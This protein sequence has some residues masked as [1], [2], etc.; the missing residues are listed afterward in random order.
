MLMPRLW[1]YQSVNKLSCFHFQPQCPLIPKWQP[2]LS[3][4][5]SWTMTWTVQRR[6]CWAAFEPHWA[7]TTQPEIWPRGWRSKRWELKTD[8]IST[9]L[10]LLAHFCSISFSQLFRFRRYV[11]FCIVHH[12]I[13]VTCYDKCVCHLRFCY[14]IAANCLFFQWFCR[15]VITDMALMIFLFIVC[16]YRLHRIL[17]HLVF[18]IQNVWRGTMEYF[19]KKLKC[20]MFNILTDTPIISTILLYIFPKYIIYILGHLADPFV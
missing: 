14:W 18:Y 5:T 7:A 20:K 3:S 16:S 19:E 4:W 12:N 8:W 11:S 17:L 9:Q 1:S 6:T 13:L 2:W 15:D 10:F